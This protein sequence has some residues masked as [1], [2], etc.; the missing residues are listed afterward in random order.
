MT[1]RLNFWEKKHRLLG[2][3]GPFLHWVYRCFAASSTHRSSPVTGNVVVAA[4]CAVPNWE[5]WHDLRIFKWV[6]DG[7]NN[8]AYL[9]QVMAFL[10]RSNRW[11]NAAKDPVHVCASL[12]DVDNRC[13]RE[14]IAQTCTQQI[15]I[16]WR[17]IFSQV[18]SYSYCLPGGKLFINSSRIWRFRFSASPQALAAIPL[19]YAVP[20]SIIRNSDMIF[21]IALQQIWD[22]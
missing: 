11:A 2:T 14:S 1:S 19:S 20:H 4:C 22:F 3:I 15:Q 7:F 13:G 8:R 6:Y 17:F 9:L 10:W 21:R 5:V 18:V 12:C 16:T